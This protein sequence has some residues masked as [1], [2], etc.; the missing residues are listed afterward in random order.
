MKHYYIL[1]FLLFAFSA[2]NKDFLN[3]EPHE[4]TDAVFW[5]TAAQAESGLA[6]VYSAL[7]DE[8]ALGGQEWAAVEALSDNAYMNDNY[9]DYIAISEFRA[10]QNTEFY[11]SLNPYKTYYKVIKRATDVLKYVPDIGMDENQKKRILGEANFLKAYGYFYLVVRFGDVPLFDSENSASAFNRAPAEQIWTTIEEHLQAATAQLNWEHQEGRPGLGAAWGLLTKVYAYREKWEPCKNAAAEVINSNQHNLYAIYSDLY[12]LEHD[13]ESEHLWVHNARLGENPVTSIL[14]LPNDVWGGTHPEQLGAGWRLVSPT[15]HFYDTYQTGD[16]RKK[17]TVAQKDVDIITYNGYT[18][19]LKAPNNQSPVVCIKYMQPYAAGYTAWGTG[20]NTP[21]LRYADILLLHAEA[22]L[23]INNAGP[24]NRTVGVSEAANSLNRVRQ[25]AGLDPIAAPTFNDLMYE[26]RME[27]AFEGGDR[28]FDL[29][30]WKLAEE[31]YNSL[32]AEG[33][34]KPKRVFNPSV[35]N[36]LPY[37][38]TE[39]DISNGSLTQNP[40]Y[41]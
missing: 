15:K 9:A 23:N 32:P 19:V 13:N 41:N 14:F 5:K 26:R 30:R 17:V 20:L 25:R 16:V 24:Q 38:Q 18:D 3:K 28:H 21:A 7:M 33:T 34:Y 8:D 4:L 31:I 11:L 35:H 12:T 6:G 29:V 22:I 2:C 36:L 27:L 10:V 1:F 39:I 40:G 37:P